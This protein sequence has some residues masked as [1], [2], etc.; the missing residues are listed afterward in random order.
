[1]LSSRENTFA[2][3]ETQDEMRW[4]LRLPR[5]DGVFIQAANKGEKIYHM[6]IFIMFSTIKDKWPV[7]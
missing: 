2:I 3:I 1:M 5:L 7:H 6:N 4:V